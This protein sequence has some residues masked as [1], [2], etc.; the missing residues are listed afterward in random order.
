MEPAVEQP[1][2][3]RRFARSVT[4]P[5]RRGTTTA[6]GLAVLGLV[7]GLLSVVPVLEEPGYLRALPAREAELVRGALFQA[8]MVVGYAGFALALYPAL[9]RVSPSLA[10][11]FV[12]FRLVGC[13]FHL[14]AVAMLPL[15]LD[16]G[17]GLDGGADPQ[18]YE[19]LVETVRRGRDLVNHVVV[20]VAVTLGDLLLFTVLYRG[21]LVPRWLSGWGLLG[22]ALAIVASLLLVSRTVEVVSVPYLSLNAPLAVHTLVLAGW[23]VARGFDPTRLPARATIPA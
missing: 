6:G 22:A 15:V 17:R 2:R 13:G 16:L 14:L 19:A 7:A 20:V 10:L 8:L 3:A 9:R 11:G 1:G 12:G 18:T 21:R 5:A 23:L 4:E